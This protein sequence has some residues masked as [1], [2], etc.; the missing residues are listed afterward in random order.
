MRGFGSDNHASV[1]PQILRALQECDGGHQP[2]YGTDPITQAAEKLFK[3][4]FA[5]QNLTA[6]FV[7]NGTGANVIALRALAKPWQ[8]VFCS[9]VAHI[10]VDECGAPESL[11]GFKLQ[12]VPST[13]GK[14]TVAALEKAYIRRGDQ[15]YSQAVALSITQPTEL[16]TTYTLS[17]L[18]TLCDWAHKHKLKIHIDGARIANAVASQNSSFREMFTENKVDIISFGGTK[19]GL[20]MGEAVLCLNPVLSEDLKF[21]R[22]QTAQLPS[23]SRYIASQFKAY[24]SDNL[25]QD[26]AKHSLLMAQS[27]FEQIQTIP[28][29]KIPFATT[30][31]AV[32]ASIPK[33]WVK[34]L[35]EV[36]FFYVWDEQET[37]CRW[38]TSWDTQPEDIQRFVEKL[39]EL[40]HETS[41]RSLS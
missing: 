36:G 37:L 14:L 38:M 27:L 25:W 7:F 32:F 29:V 13:D 5:S 33:T 30:S 24:L 40:S 11:G 4:L 23:K 20:M 41:S 34:P 15:H 35:R 10:Q 22:K 9:D 1:H 12:V 39:K 3:E 28:Q 31:N 21:I 18:K 17:E 2:S 26:I 16:G 8:A 19:N 6:H